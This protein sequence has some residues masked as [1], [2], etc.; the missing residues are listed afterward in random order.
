MSARRIK[1][2]CVR[3]SRPACAAQRHDTS[4]KCPPSSVKLRWIGS[5]A[6]SEWG[7]CQASPSQTSSP[8][9]RYSWRP[10]QSEHS[11]AAIQRPTVQASLDADTSAH[12]SQTA[13][14]LAATAA[15][16][17][18]RRGPQT[19]RPTGKT[20]G[21]A[22]CM[23]GTCQARQMRLNTREP[24]VPPKPKLFFRATSIFRSR[25]VLAQ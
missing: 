22:L 12:T 10:H 8:S 1:A 5:S 18:A 15:S 11:A 13:K 2:C 19:K 16:K 4:M 25:A 6:P 9:C 24:L 14:T 23:A 3:T 20:T 21:G 17:R 7:P